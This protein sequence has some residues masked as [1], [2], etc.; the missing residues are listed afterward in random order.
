MGGFGEG[1]GGFWEGLKGISRL[2]FAFLSK[3]AILLKIA[4][5]LGKTNI[6][7]VSS[8]LKSP[9]NPIKINANAERG[10]RSAKL[11][12]KVDLGGSWAAFG[13]DLGGL[14]LQVGAKLNQVG[15]KIEILASSGCSWAPFGRIL[16][17]KSCQHGRQGI[18]RR[19][20]EWIFGGFSV[21]F[22]ADFA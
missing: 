22:N 19:L 16:V 8:S 1:F 4:F 11:V 2:F 10:D 14:G 20:Q 3:I 7:Q 5:S 9:K 12:V 17:P 18:P 6:F 13:Q 21:D 15:P